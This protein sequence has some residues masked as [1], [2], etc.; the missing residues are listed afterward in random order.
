MRYRDAVLR[1]AGEPNNPVMGV[2]G[3]AGETGEVVELVKKLTFHGRSFDR[4]RMVEELGDVRWYMEYLAACFDISM[5]EIE[6][7]NVKKLEARY[8][9]G[10]VKTETDHQVVS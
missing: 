1:T 2:L 10:F 4:Q 7:E 8:P 5:A 9:N 6:Q 3:L